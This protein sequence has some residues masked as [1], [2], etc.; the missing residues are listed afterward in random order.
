MTGLVERWRV[1]F[2]GRVWQRYGAARGSVL[3]AGIAY[4]AFFSIFPALAIGFTVL[5]LVVGDDNSLR[6]DLADYVNRSL[7]VTAIGVPGGAPGIVTL[8][9]LVQPRALTVS[10][11]VGFVTL[12]LTGLGWLASVRDGVRGVFGRSGSGSPLLGKVRDA[13]MLATF[14]VAA[15]VSVA[16]SLFVTTA[17]TTVLGWLGLQ[18]TTGSRTLVTVLSTAA[19]VAVDAVIFLVLFRVLS[20]V[21]VPWRHLR[22][23][24][25]AGAVGLGLLKLAGGLL[26]DRMS[27]NRFLAAF[28]IVVGL[29]VWMNLVGRLTLLAASWAA[30]RAADAGELPA[31]VLGGPVPDGADTPAEARA[32]VGPQQVARVP[33]YGV[34]AADRTSLAAGVVLG[35]AGAAVLRVARGAVRT[36]VG[37]VRD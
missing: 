33:T 2:L 9:A 10:A 15:L 32:A 7:G 17:S 34:R 19:L 26:L 37:A 22:D 3:A 20:D 12:F 5:G 36:V 35:L 14:G 30:T 4:Y 18:G 6:R 8:D 11:A 16:V 23:G 28:S 27:A 13:G 25:L 29:L 24:A 31:V 21:D 1:S